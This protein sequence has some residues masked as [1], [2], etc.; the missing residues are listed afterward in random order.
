MFVTRALAV[1]AAVSVSTSALFDL[2]AFFVPATSASD[3]DLSAVVAGAAEECKQA[4]PAAKD[5]NQCFKCTAN[6]VWYKCASSQSFEACDVPY[7]NAYG[8]AA[9]EITPMPCAGSRSQWTGV[10]C[11]GNESAAGL[12][13]DENDSCKRSWDD[14]NGVACPQ[15][16]TCPEP[17]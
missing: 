13:Y 6:S 10:S 2:P 14:G 12:C 3:A 1:F 7:F 17:E 11:G 8:C 16:T 4:G 5:C 15:S 9:C